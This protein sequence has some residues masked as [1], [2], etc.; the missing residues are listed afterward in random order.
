MSAHQAAELSAFRQQVRDFIEANADD[1]IREAGRKTTSFFPPFDQVMKWHRILHSQGWSAIRWPEEYGG[2][3]WD[4][5]RQ[6]IFEEECRRAGVP[7]LLPQSISMVGPAII[8][9]GTDGQKQKH[10]PGILSGDDFWAQGYSEPNAGS[11]LA[12]LRC[13]AER[14]GDHYVINGSKTWTTY[15]HHANRMFLLVRT[16]GAG[17]PQQ[18]I[19]FFLIEDLTDPGIEIRPIIGLDGLPEQC[20]VFFTN[21]RVPVDCCLGEKNDG[22]SVAKYLLEHERGGGTSFATTFRHELALILRLARRTGDG[23]GGTLADDGA[24]QD[25]YMRLVLEVDTLEATEEQFAAME[26]GSPQSGPMSSMIKII[27]METLQR[28][29]EMAIDVAGSPSL[30][31][32]LAALTVGSGVEPI[33]DED[34]LTLMPK[35]LNNRAASIFGGSN[36]I[37]RNIIAKSLLR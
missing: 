33:G 4:V 12:S 20:D 37:Q 31:L 10:L 34:A 16:G 14:D 28:I 23:F 32:Q 8:H 1:E 7:L 9:Y 13:R 36:E 21:V 27:S 35:Y 22:W 29:N 26:K 18:G 24:F 19:S 5:P 15:A 2:T 25:R 11:D 17:K 30:P 6:L 3:G